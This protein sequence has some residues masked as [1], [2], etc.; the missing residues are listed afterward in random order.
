MDEI[1]RAAT[2]VQEEAVDFL[3]ELIRIPSPSGGEAEVVEAIRKKMKEVGF[4]EVRIDPFGN[5]LGRVGQGPRVLA[6][7]AHVDTVGVGDPQSWEVDPFAAEMYDG[8][9][10]GRGASD[11]K[12]GMAALVYTGAIIRSLGI[13]DG[14]TV[15]VVGSVLEEDCDG[16]CWHYILQEEILHPDVVV[17]TEPTD[18][19]V[20]RGQRGRMEIEVTTHGVSAHGSAPERGIN[21]IYRMAPIIGEIERLNQKFSADP[22]LGSGSVTISQVRSTAPSLC[23][24]AD[25]CTL[26][27]DRRLTIGETDESAVAQIERLVKG[28]PGDAEITVP[29]FNRPSHTGLVYPMRQYFPAWALPESHDLVRLGIR[30]RQMILGEGEPPGRWM[31]STNGVATMGLHD[32]PTI[33]FGPAS[34]VHAH[35]PTD[36]CPVEH[37]GAA[38]AFYAAFTMLFAGEV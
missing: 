12:G 1:R 15:W 10:Y 8:V 11:Q 6:F 19:N 36:Q 9:V 21:A 13:G 32:V 3:R 34:E 5:V 2:G 20:Y 25:S 27:L 4:D 16:L 14:T 26:H 28:K 29:V 7:D 33:G 23:A 17:L 38:I 31:F 35:A 37:I 22:F 18:L 30:A 24:V